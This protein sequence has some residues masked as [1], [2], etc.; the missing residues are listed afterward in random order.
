M[1]IINLKTLIKSFKYAI[2]GIRYTFRHEQNFRIQSFIA[3]VVVIFMFVFEISR[4]EAVILFLL[5]LLVLVLELINTTLEKVV[6]I[7]KPRI[8]H[9]V[10]VIKD[11]MAAMVFLA[12][13]GSLI[14]GILIFWP[15][16]FS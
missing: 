3:L 11:L 9:Y 10:E 15:Y 14:I 12:S 6:D 16:I 5:I 8:H 1:P 7:L 4:G 2:K 13:L